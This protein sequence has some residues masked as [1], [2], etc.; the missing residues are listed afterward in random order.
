M[1]YLKCVQELVNNEKDL[2]VWITDFHVNNGCIFH[3]KKTSSAFRIEATKKI[4]LWCVCVDGC[5]IKD[6][7]GVNIPKCDNLA[8]SDEEF[9]F[10]ESK[11]NV[12]SE[13]KDWITK[14]I[15]DAIEN[16]IKRTK[17]ILLDRISDAGHEFSSKNIKIFIAFPGTNYVVPKNNVQIVEKLRIQATKTLNMPIKKFILDDKISFK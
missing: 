8:F 1:P 4:K 16:K 6:S 17:E 2:A 14:E 5:L 7:K 3:D 11:M 9:Y 12:K 15:Q 13:K 10:I